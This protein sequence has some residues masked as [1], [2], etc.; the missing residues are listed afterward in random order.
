MKLRT[1]VGYIFLGMTLL[2]CTAKDETIPPP[3]VKI[4]KEYKNT[5]TVAEMNKKLTSFRRPIQGTYL[6]RQKRETSKE[7]YALIYDTKQYKN[8][9]Q[10]FTKLHPVKRKKKRVKKIKRKKITKKIVTKKVSSENENK[11]KFY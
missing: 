6:S 4:V 2:G 7:I 1:Y 3:S 10:R 8:D 9:M 11:L 5:R